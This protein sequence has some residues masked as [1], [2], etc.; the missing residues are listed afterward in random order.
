MSNTR[1]DATYTEEKH[2]NYI[3]VTKKEGNYSISGEHYH[4]VICDK[5]RKF[6]NVFY[7]KPVA[8]IYLI[9][10]LDVQIASTK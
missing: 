5:G 8:L 10:L 3:L 6:I 2:G 9:G 7:S 4:Y 1:K